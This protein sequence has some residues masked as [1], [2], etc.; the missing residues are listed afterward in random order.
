MAPNQSKMI[1]TIIDGV[2]GR[3]LLVEGF[4]TKYGEDVRDV[5]YWCEDEF[6]NIYEPSP[7]PPHPSG[8]KDYVY[9]KWD[10]QSKCMREYSEPAWK[11][12]LRANNRADTPEVR[13]SI[14]R[15]IWMNGEANRPCGC[16]TNSHA[17][18]L[19]SPCKETNYRK[20]KVCVGSWGFKLKAGLIE[21]NWG[22]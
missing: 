22:Q 11:N 18:A 15:E 16:H 1:Y 3:S 12:L 13:Q 17:L 21:I 6:G 8:L 7:V 9:I 4:N 14:M 19:A 5:H 20:V 10:N 2:R